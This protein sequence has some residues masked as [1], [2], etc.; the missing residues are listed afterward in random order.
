MAWKR[1]P[2][3]TWNARLSPPCPAR[4]YRAIGSTLVTMVLWMYS[5]T[6]IHS[7]RSSGG[8][9]CA[10]CC[11]SGG[12]SGSSSLAIVAI[13]VRSVRPGDPFLGCLD[14]SLKRCLFVLVANV[15]IHTSA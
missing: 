1:E 11:R 2:P 5:T 8:A 3:A 10:C 15:L 12:G 6:W 13:I 9:G 4:H 14:E 7:T